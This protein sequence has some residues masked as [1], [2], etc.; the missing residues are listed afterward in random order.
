MDIARMNQPPA[1]L[2]TIAVPVFNGE[3]ALAPMLVSL[4]S[5]DWNLFEVRFSDDGSADDTC[6]VLDEFAAKHPGHVFVESHENI[7][8]GP[9]RNRLLAQARGEWLW[10]CDADDELAPGAIAR[11]AEIL[12][13]RPVDMLAFLY[14]QGSFP[15][16]AEAAR[17]GACPI[18]LSR[19]K[20][21]LSIL[22]ATVAKVIR[23]G[24]LRE[25][26][27]TFAPLRAGEDFLFTATAAC[28]CESSLF[29][30]AKPYWA[31]NGFWQN[32]GTDHLT[33]DVDD[34]YC[35]DVSEALRQMRGLQDRH[36]DLAMEIG[37]QRWILAAHFR[38]RVR[39]EAGPAVREKWLP[40][41][42]A[43]LHEMAEAQDNPLLR[44]PRSFKR[45]EDA[46]R[47]REREALKREREALK[48]EE[49]A[50]RREQAAVRREQEIRASLSWRI[51]A[52]L[53]RCVEALKRLS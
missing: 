20:L 6:R 27:I 28:A 25:Q 19:Q 18:P 23:T 30:H 50:Q 17:L 11:I 46:A 8:P 34:R 13:E 36:P 22:G 10:F 45:R 3:A 32:D 7:G 44:V 38:D 41:A 14:G 4:D 48:R 52:P 12:R 37:L 51:T 24:L 43:A 47:R 31:R 5:Q 33:R 1:P 49:A 9:C 35:E 2:L 29:W 15:G 42:Q 40:A 39:D 21:L 53:R 16:D 26:G